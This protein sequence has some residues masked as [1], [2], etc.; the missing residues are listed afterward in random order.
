[1]K[2]FLQT[3]QGRL[4]INSF[5]LLA[6]LAIET[7]VLRISVTKIFLQQV[8]P[9]WPA[10][11]SRNLIFFGFLTLVI[12]FILLKEETEVPTVT[13]RPKLFYLIM[14]LIF[15][16]S[17]FGLSAWM[18][19][20][21]S[22]HTVHGH[23]YGYVWWLLGFLILLSGTLIFFRGSEVLELVKTFPGQIARSIILGLVYILTYPFVQNL[24][25]YFAEI[26]MYGS[27]VL[28]TLTFPETYIRAADHV[29]GLQNSDFSVMIVKPC[30]GI[31]GITL[32]LLIYTLVVILNWKEMNKVK[33]ILL[34][35]SGLAM[36]IFANIVRIYLILALAFIVHYWKGAKFGTDLA[37]NQFHSHFGWILYSV[38]IFLFVKL[39]SK[40][41]RT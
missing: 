17:F 41:V 23:L 5:L 40:W 35:I 24:W 39:T 4:L 31:E 2:K 25:K 36:M 14:N 13:A 12:F 6:F 11:F 37:V 21:P 9:P 20:E 29:I 34:Y 32:F 26:T 8:Y 18:G 22:R 33:T 16:F 3:S 38:I 10:A 30:S 27:G 7:A 19:A 15:F 28:L 1:M